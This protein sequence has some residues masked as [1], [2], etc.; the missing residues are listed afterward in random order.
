MANKKGRMSKQDWEVIQKLAGEMSA[1]D[2]AK[3][4]DRTAESVEKY[5]SENIP[6]D[7]VF[8]SKDVELEDL[9]RH[10]IKQDLR[11]KKIWLNLKEEFSGEE[12]GFFEEQYVAL[13][14]QFKGDVLATEETQVFQ[15]IKYQ[16]LMSRNLRSRKEAIGDITAA[17]KEQD[18]LS[19]MV[20]R[21][22][23]TDEDRNRLLQIEQHIVSI[24]AAETSRTT[25]YVKLQERHDKLMENLKATRNQRIDKV[26]NGNISFLEVIKELEKKDVQ[27][28][29]ARMMTLTK[30][31]TQEQEKRF[32][33]ELK[34]DDDTFDR[35][36]LSADSMKYQDEE[37]T[38]D[39]EE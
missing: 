23:A 17:M 33:Q 11:G 36:I 7:Q 14:E 29:E 37:E 34:Y 24:K 39:V 31:A 5:I 15:V 32:Y 4:L 20:M 22:T 35:P 1:A 18:K 9:E 38:D 13:M 28:R 26:A 21:G 6:P 2:I 19:E 25:E 8:D 30:I 27:D 10:A 16:I 12:I 3:R